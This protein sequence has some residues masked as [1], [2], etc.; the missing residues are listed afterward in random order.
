VDLN[1][2]IRELVTVPYGEAIRAGVT[3]SRQ[4]APQLQGVGRESGPRQQVV[5]NLVV[6]PFAM[7]SEPLLQDTISS[8]PGC[9]RFSPFRWRM[10]MVWCLSTSGWWSRPKRSEPQKERW[11]AGCVYSKTCRDI[12]RGSPI[13]VMWEV[14]EVYRFPHDGVGHAR[15]RRLGARLR[16]APLPLPFVLICAGA[17]VRRQVNACTAPSLSRILVTQGGRTDD[18]RNK[19]RNGF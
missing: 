2:A 18:P 8:A 19:V 7:I 3:A 17:L 15:M 11:A 9:S 5:L 1:E 4:L 6:T 14:V 16:C 12:R 13:S 10:S